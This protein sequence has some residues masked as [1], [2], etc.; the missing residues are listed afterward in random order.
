[1]GRAAKS[2]LRE[3]RQRVNLRK[4]CPF[5]FEGEHIGGRNH[6]P[7]VIVDVCQKHHAQLT[8]E[9]LASGAE[10]K[11][12][13]HP[14]KSVEMALRSLAVTARAI[15]YATQ[16]LSEGMEFSADVLKKAWRK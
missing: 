13:P 6:L 8:E 3:S 11:K 12:Q 7:H 16:K 14:T 9:R 1:M 10:M 4:V 15:G 2:V 5:C